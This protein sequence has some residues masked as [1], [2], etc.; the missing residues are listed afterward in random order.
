MPTIRQPR[1]AVRI[2]AGLL[3]L[4]APALIASCGS[5]AKKSTVTTVAGTTPEEH[6]ADDAAVSAGL[7]KMVATAT[8]VSASVAAGTKV[9]DAG[10]QLEANWSDVEGA[11]KT[12]DANTYLAIE[13]AMTAI[14]TA[15]KDG[16]AAGTAKASGNLTTAISGYLADHP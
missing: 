4:S 8:A 1:P 9:T 5:D 16:D 14:D 10:D 6:Q 11:V 12:N 2:L 3:A 15:G 7:S 13:D